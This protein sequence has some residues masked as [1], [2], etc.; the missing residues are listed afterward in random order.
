MPNS[1]YDFSV[2]Q[3]TGEILDLNSLQ[4]KVLLIV[5][6]ASRCGFTYQYAELETLYQRY[7]QQGLEILAFPC[8]QFLHQEP[9]E[10]QQIKE[11]CQMMFNLSFPL[12]E[13]IEVNGANTHPLFNYLK[14][15]APGFLG[16]TSI[17]WN[18]TKF[19]VTRNGQTIVRFPPY[20]KPLRL[21]NRIRNLLD[22]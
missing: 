6:T 1:I 17:K 19:L 18:F 15:A 16:S 14:S 11:Y 3:N 4:G 2:R 21:E 8:N 10:N 20:L 13:K 7:H 9:W 5:N 22:E 12:M